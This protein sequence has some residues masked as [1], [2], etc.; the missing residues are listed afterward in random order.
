[1]PEPD[2]KQDGSRPVGGQLALWPHIFQKK[3]PNNE[4]WKLVT[5]MPSDLHHWRMSLMG[6]NGKEAPDTFVMVAYV[7]EPGDTDWFPLFQ[8]VEPAWRYDYPPHVYAK[9]FTAG[10]GNSDYD[11]VVVEAWTSKMPAQYKDKEKSK[12]GV[13]GNRQQ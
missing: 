5:K 8:G 6:E 7:E 11:I 12:A 2:G 3:L 10:P 13:I 1:V 4:D 9:A